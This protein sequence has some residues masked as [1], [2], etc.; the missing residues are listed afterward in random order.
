DYVQPSAYGYGKQL[1]FVAPLVYL[2][3][4]NVGCGIGDLAS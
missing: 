1:R 2:G 3:F 4:G